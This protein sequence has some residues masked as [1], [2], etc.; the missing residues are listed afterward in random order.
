MLRGERM[1][2]LAGSHL[3]CRAHVCAFFNSREEEYKVLL[4]FIEESLA[5]GD[6]VSHFCSKEQRAERLR[7]M[8]RAGI[9]AAAAEE[10]GRL[11]VHPWE[12][13]HLRGGRFDQDAMLALLRDALIADKRNGH[14]VT[15]FWGNMEWTLEDFP[16]V[17]D[18]LEYEMRVNSVLMEHDAVAVC[19]YD[20]SRF[21]V[22]F[23]VDV[24]RTH[25]FALVEG[26]VHENPFYARP[27][28]FLRELSRRSVTHEA[29]SLAYRQA[30]ATRPV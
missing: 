3:P 6:K 12:N 21:S 9:D 24:L 25:P 8:T 22:P 13:G 28:E 30:P 1:V 26:V 23:V 19:A 16:G 29:A 10:S 4:P 18:V 27:D 11:E 20:L 15:R 5:L 2:R 7:R 14:R 17:Q